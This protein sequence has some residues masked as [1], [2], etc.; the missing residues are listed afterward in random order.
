M[1]KLILL[2]ATALACAV[3]FGA[4]RA[5]TPDMWGGKTNS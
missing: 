1:E 4:I 3:S 2:S 5:V